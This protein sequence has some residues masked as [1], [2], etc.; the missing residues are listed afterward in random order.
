MIAM[1]LK[2]FQSMEANAIQKPHAVELRGVEKAF[3][4]R[5]ILS[6][7][8]L[9]VGQGERVVLIGASGS[10]KSTLLRVI[11]GLEQ[12]Q[13]G[14]VFVEGSLI[15]EARGK[16]DS[17]SKE[18]RSAK[19]RAEIGMVFQHFNLFPNM[20]VIANI[21]LALC[22]VRHMSKPEAI[23]LAEQMLERV[24]LLSHKNAS[25]DSLSG[26][27][28][29]RVAIARALA[30]RP[31]VMLFDEATSALDPELVGEV[32]DVMREVAAEGMTMMIVTHEMRFARDVA[33]RVV[34]MDQGNILEQG[35][36]D[37][38]LSSPREERTKAFLHRVLDH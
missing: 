21:C 4:K 38:M 2:E 27:Q 34:F 10:G 26:G 7:I 22:L 13:A 16:R 3:G 11:A 12:I 9:S 36:P 33:D 18:S 24:G 5:T 30:M 8:D 19:A 15:Q 31:R 28:K 20:S 35:H 25:P 23:T 32:L 29:Q 37:L 6:G 17:R 14:K 1:D